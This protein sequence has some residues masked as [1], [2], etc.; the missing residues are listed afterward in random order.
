MAAL[1]GKL[2][3]QVVSA[4][5]SKAEAEVWAKLQAA[6]VKGAC[7]PGKVRGI[8]HR[9]DNMPANATPPSGAA[10]VSSVASARGGGEGAVKRRN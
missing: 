4:T 7:V 1:A 3:V 5:C 8:K 6:C 2:H 10:R 9:V